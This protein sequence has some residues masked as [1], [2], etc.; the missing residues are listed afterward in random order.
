VLFAPITSHRIFKTIAVWTLMIAIV[1]CGVLAGA[2]ARRKGSAIAG[3]RISPALTTQDE[4]PSNK[5]RIDTEIIS[6]TPQGF[7]PTEIARPKGPFI[8]RIN[9][10]SGL[11]ELSLRLNSESGN[12]LV[13]VPLNNGRANWNQALDLPPDNYIISEAG[14]SGWTCNLTITSQ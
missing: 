2:T 10:R 7:E 4:P 9:N 1:L 3:D 5:P 12:N 13:V 11:G 6:I 8:L 14:H